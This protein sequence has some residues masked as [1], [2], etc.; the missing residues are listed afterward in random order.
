MQIT[1]TNFND[2]FAPKARISRRTRGEML[3]TKLTVGQIAVHVMCTSPKL[4]FC[5]IVPLDAGQNQ[6]NTFI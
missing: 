3:Y 2:I 1:K 6:L 5:A 4:L